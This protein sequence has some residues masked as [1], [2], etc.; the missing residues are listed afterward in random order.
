[1]P[2]SRG[3]SLWTEMAKKVAVD[4]RATQPD[5]KVSQSLRFGSYENIRQWFGQTYD[6][7]SRIT[8]RHKVGLHLW[9]QRWLQKVAVDLRATQPDRKV[10]QSL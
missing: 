2:R 4:L 1:M 7:N 6:P 5:R 8:G 9:G 10:G 3:T